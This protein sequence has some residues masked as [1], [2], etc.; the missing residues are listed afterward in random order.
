MTLCFLPDQDFFSP[1]RLSIFR[2]LQSANRGKGS[3]MFLHSRSTPLRSL[4][5]DKQRKKPLK[6]LCH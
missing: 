3:P 5:G 1:A 6:F 4:R 2:L